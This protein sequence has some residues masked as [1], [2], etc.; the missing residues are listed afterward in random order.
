MVNFHLGNLTLCTFSAED[1]RLAASP[2]EGEQ[3][4]AGTAR[5][6]FMNGVCGGAIAGPC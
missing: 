6:S 5:G 1:M 3:N 4:L 2:P